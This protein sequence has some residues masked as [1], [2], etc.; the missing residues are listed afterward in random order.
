M[1]EFRFM[2]LLSVV[3]SA[4]CLTF[5]SCGKTRELEEYYRQNENNTPVI[6]TR[7]TVAITQATKEMTLSEAEVLAKSYVKNKYQ[8]YSPVVIGSVDHKASYDTAQY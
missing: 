7:K 1:R 4:T 8:D 6:T 3:L 2:V 5:S